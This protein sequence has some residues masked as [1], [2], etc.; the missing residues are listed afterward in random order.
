MKIWAMSPYI[1]IFVLTFW[2]FNSF[3]DLNRPLTMEEIRKLENNIIKD[4]E[5]VNSRRF[6]ADH[7]ALQSNWKQVAQYLSPVAENLPIKYVHLLVRA[8]LQLH[9][10]RE[11]ESFIRIPLSAKKVTLDSYI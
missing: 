7:F 2:G 1:F 9:Q 3:A 5:N 6:L 10:V 8:H 11:A 4:P